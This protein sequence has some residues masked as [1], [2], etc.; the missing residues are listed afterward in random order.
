L[1]KAPA[2]VATRICASIHASQLVPGGLRFIMVL[3]SPHQ[4]DSASLAAPSPTPL[5]SSL[6]SRYNR[7]PPALR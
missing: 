5:R 4:N 3:Q 7:D 6:E 2:S 1:S